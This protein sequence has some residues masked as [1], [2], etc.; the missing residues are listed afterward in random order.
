MTARSF[1]RGAVLAVASAALL[2]ATACYRDFINASP[3]VRWWLFSNFGAQKMCPEMLKRGAMLRLVPNGNG[4]GRFFPNRCVHT[5]N[6][7]TRTITIDF[8]GTGYAWTPIAGRVGFASNAAVEYRPDFQLTDDAMY[9]WAKTNR[10]VRPAEFTIGSVENKVVD[11]AA[12]TPAGYLANTFGG[13]I[14]QGQLASGFTVV[15]TDQG[16][17]FALGIIVPPARPKHPFSIEDDDRYVFANETSEVRNGQV[18]FLGP[19]EVA[20]GDQAL[21]FRFRVQGPALDAFLLPRSAADYWRE[22]LQRG[23]ALAPP[24]QPPISGFVIPPGQSDQRMRVPRG[25]YVLVVDNSAAVGSV[26]PPW[27]PLSVLGANVA[28]LSYSAELVEVD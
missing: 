27:N 7:A 12:K 14:V 23:Q 21:I 25:E 19:F 8:G 17:D 3:G 6:D 10:V 20:E 4:V 13:Q 24:P 16:D 28:L 26:S 1:L 2:A 9:L 15:R 22:G 5:V 18:D 11:W